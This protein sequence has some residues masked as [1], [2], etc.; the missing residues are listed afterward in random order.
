MVRTSRSRRK[1]FQRCGSAVLLTTKVSCGFVCCVAWY[2]TNLIHPWLD[3]FAQHRSI[4]VLLTAVSQ[5]WW[6]LARICK[7]LSFY[8]GGIF[9]S[10]FCAMLRLKRAPSVTVTQNVHQK[11]MNPSSERLLHA[12]NQNVQFVTYTVSSY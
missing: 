5:V 10:E 8:M 2:S 9:P 7:V 11:L 1:G 6:C 3:S 4:L 12:Q